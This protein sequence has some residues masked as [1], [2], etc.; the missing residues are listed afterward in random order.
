MKLKTKTIEPTFSVE[1][2][3][4]A[5]NIPKSTIRHKCQ[6]L[7]F[8]PITFNGNSEYRLYKNEVE[9]LSAYKIRKEIPEIIYVHTTW[10]I[11]ES[12]LNFGL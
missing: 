8:R 7:G 3:S 6:S 12:K 11:L 5:Y 4:N 9:M 10:I 1:D 2:I